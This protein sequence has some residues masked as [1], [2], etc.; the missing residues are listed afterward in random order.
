MKTFLVMSDS[1]EKYCMGIACSILL[2]FN[3]TD[4]WT[5]NVDV[6]PRRLDTTCTLQKQ[7]PP[8]HRSPLE[9]FSC[10][11]LHFTVYTN[12]GTAKCGK[13]T[14]DA[15]PTC[16]WSTKRRMLSSDEKSDYCFNLP[17]E[18]RLTAKLKLF[19]SATNYLDPKCF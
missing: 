7:S 2:N 9:L 19:N 11:R 12:Y 13:S 6:T 16:T 3:V 15:D 5:I 18:L 8:T 4:Y 1:S 10:T 17:A 14:P